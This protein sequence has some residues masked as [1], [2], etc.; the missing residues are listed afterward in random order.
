MLN[1]LSVQVAATIGAEGIL[2][3]YQELQTGDN[4]RQEAD[5]CWILAGEETSSAVSRTALG[6]SALKGI[7]RAGVG[8]PE[9]A[10]AAVKA[11]I[12]LEGAT[13]ETLG[14]RALVYMALMTVKQP[15]ELQ[16]VLTALQSAQQAD[17]SWEG[18]AYTTALVL[19][20]LSLVE[21]PEVGD[22]P[23]LIVRS[24]TISFDPETPF[25]GQTV[26]IYATIFND[27]TADAEDVVVEFFKGDP[28]LGGTAIGTPQTIA[29]IPSSASAVRSVG[30]DTTGL[31]G[32]QL[33]V[34]FAAR[35]NLILELN[36]AD[37]AVAKT[38]AV[39]GNPDLEVAS[40]DITY[41][42]AAPKAFEQIEIVMRRVNCKDL[43]VPEVIEALYKPSTALACTEPCKTSGTL[44][45]VN[46]TDFLFDL[47]LELLEIQRRKQPRIQIEIMLR[48]R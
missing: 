21:P 46:D 26:S 18:D 19:Q 48:S 24:E 23:N 3:Q 36:E 7:E 4:D 39:A 14:D 13:A 5:G 16:D 27:G 29:S 45:V 31:I 35:A 42:P 2:W 25:S 30:L 47:R 43:L 38:L 11:Q 28:R 6:L 20:A 9:L 34:V 44:D 40:A 37:N 8:S 1:G 17:G 33:I 15:S 41:L 32:P 22:L 12:F 10:A